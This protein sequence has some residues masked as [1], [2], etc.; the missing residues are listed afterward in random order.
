M[1]K[2][3]GVTRSAFSVLLYYMGIIAN[4]YSKLDAK[5][6]TLPRILRNAINL[7]LIAGLFWMAYKLLSVMALWITGLIWYYG[8][9]V[10]HK[11]FPDITSGTL[12]FALFIALSIVMATVAVCLAIW[13]SK[14]ESRKP[15][16]N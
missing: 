11:V 16:D 3:T 12:L 4:L 10:I 5:L 9:I 14:T 15:T 8:N 6:S 2:P 13:V 1:E 7:V